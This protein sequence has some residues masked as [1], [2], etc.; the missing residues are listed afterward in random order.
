[1]R[2]VEYRQEKMIPVL[3]HGRSD[4]SAYSRVRGCPW[5]T[6]A[7]VCERTLSDIRESDG[8]SKRRTIYY[9]Y[10]SDNREEMT[11]AGARTDQRWLMSENSP[12]MK[13]S[14]GKHD[15]SLKVMNEGVLLYFLAWNSSFFYTSAWFNAR[16]L[17][18]AQVQATVRTPSRRKLQSSHALLKR[19][20]RRS[21]ESTPD[22]KILFFD[23]ILTLHWWWGK[24][25]SF[26]FCSIFPRALNSA[27]LNRIIIA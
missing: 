9:L 23:Q 24:I 3:C 14:F 25:C 27:Y 19:S 2:R 16:V 7:Y 11:H 18:P 17:V 1:M 6:Y 4:H 20:T 5:M 12:S 21:E 26:I 8:C 15:Q 10:A 22:G 13:L